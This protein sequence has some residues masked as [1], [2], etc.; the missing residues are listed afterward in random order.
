MSSSARPQP[1][2]EKL[3]VGELLQQIA[4]PD[5]APGGGFAA[6]ITLA[7]AA[8]LVT[9]AARM[10]HGSWPEAG[11]AAAQAE[12]L[13]SRAAVLAE[14]NSQA[15]LDALAALRA[16]SSA[17]PAQRDDRIARALERAADVPIEIAEMAVDVASLAASV[18]EGGEPSLRADVAVAA[19]LAAGVARSAQ[20]LVEVNLGTRSGDERVSEARELVVAASA[21]AQRAQ[22][23]VD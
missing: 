19:S 5:P 14:E 22:D 23:A 2:I 1:R 6:G 3:Q 13:R 9:M 15:Y 8:G 17:E 10:S 4:S 20:T 7:I 16:G 21:A 18:A 11:G 12:A